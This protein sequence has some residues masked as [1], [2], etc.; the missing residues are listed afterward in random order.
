MPRLCQA[1]K[2]RVTGLSSYPSGRP[3]VYWGDER[4][5]GRVLQSTHPEDETVAVEKAW[6]RE[7]RGAG[8]GGRRC[9]RHSQKLQLGIKVLLLGARWQLF[10]QV[11]VGGPWG[12]FS[13]ALAPSTSSKGIF[14]G[15]NKQGAS[16]VLQ[17]D[18]HTHR[19]MHR[20]WAKCW[21]DYFCFPL[22]AT[23]GEIKDIPFPPKQTGLCT[24]ACQEV[25]KSPLE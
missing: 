15:P 7:L 19:H 3:P 22:T 10:C 12:A 8:G 23:T 24:G 25:K 11:S 4:Q 14:N 6:Q 9:S 20:K 1:E 5:K 21:A 18:T 2:T 16:L 13:A 17:T